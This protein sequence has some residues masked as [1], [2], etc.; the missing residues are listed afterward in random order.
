M[1]Y[2]K[3]YWIPGE[4]RSNK[5]IEGL[6]FDISCSLNMFIKTIRATLTLLFFYF[7]LNCFC[8]PEKNVTF[9]SI[10]IRVSRKIWITQK[11]SIAKNAPKGILIETNNAKYLYFFKRK[12]A[13]FV[14]FWFECSCVPIL[15]CKSIIF[16]LSRH[17]LV[18]NKY[19]D[20]K[21]YQFIRHWPLR[22]RFIWW[23]L[24]LFYRYYAKKT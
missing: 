4:K 2:K 12:V 10:N 13:Q 14:D 3:L 17:F 16:W 7:I 15:L 1:N 19:F 18:R 6:Y 8:K 20:L 21:K 11:K 24:R 22:K 5:S 23:F 9:F